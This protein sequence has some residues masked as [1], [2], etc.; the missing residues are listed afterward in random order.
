MM[1]NVTTR[2]I[3]QGETISLGAMLTGTKASKSIQKISADVQKAVHQGK[4]MASQIFF[5]GTVTKV[6]SGYAYAV[7]QYIKDQGYDVQEQSHSKKYPSID[8][9]RARLEAE[10]EEIKPIITFKSTL[11]EY[12]SIDVEKRQSIV[13]K[14]DELAASNE[15]RSLVYGPGKIIS[16]LH[17][18]KEEIAQNLDLLGT[19]QYGKN[20]FGYQIAKVNNLA[21]IV[22]EKERSNQTAN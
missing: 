14:L 21:K 19:L 12:V 22:L 4:L 13:S 10:P 8:D 9:L 2:K 11:P 18:S 6:V 1:K 20:G 16:E 3:K 7:K 15:G 5:H 17:I